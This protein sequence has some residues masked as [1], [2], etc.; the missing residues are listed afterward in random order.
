MLGQMEN[1]YR[2]DGEHQSSE[3]QLQAGRIEFSFAAMKLRADVRDWPAFRV[4]VVRNGGIHDDF[5]DLTRGCG[6][7]AG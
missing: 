2:L 6:E 1:R 5:V 4:P 3:S 7:Y